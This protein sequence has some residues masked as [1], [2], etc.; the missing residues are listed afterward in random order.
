MFLF[1]KL[2]KTRSYNSTGEPAPA[3]S[4][5][6]LNLLMFAFWHTESAAAAVTAAKNNVREVIERERRKEI[7]RTAAVVATT[8]VKEDI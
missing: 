8:K 2:G 4:I 1:P 6:I 3:P 7:K 5:R